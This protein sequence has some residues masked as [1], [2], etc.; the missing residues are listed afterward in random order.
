MRAK[1]VVAVMIFI[2]ISAISPAM[3][4]NEDRYSYI[5][6]EDVTIG[7]DNGTANIHVNYSV[8][9]GTRFIFF[10]FGKQDL[11]NKLLKILNYDDAQMKY[12]N[13]SAAEFS[14]KSASFSYGDGIYWY[15]SH[16]FNIVIP[17]LTV[18]TPQVTRVFTMTK[19]FPGGIGYFAITNPRPPV[20]QGPANNEISISGSK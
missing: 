9:E 15:P 2:L 5:T 1:A 7:L 11:R 12:I 13:L 10:L 16:Q 18:K 3:A 19:D 8:D 6:V 14:V 4:A 20:L 17:V